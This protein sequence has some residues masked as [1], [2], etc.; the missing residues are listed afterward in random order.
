MICILSFGKYSPVLTLYN[1]D[2]EGNLIQQ[3]EVKSDFFDAGQADSTIA[4][5]TNK[6]NFVVKRW[7]GFEIDN[8]NIVDS[9][10]TTTYTI[11]RTGKIMKGTRSID[12]RVRR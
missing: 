6:S 8:G 5:F 2:P 12:S 10:T 7:D 1:Y 4:Y 11:D 3:I 9:V